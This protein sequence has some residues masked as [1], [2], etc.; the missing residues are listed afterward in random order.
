MMISAGRRRRRRSGAAKSRWL[1]LGSRVQYSWQRGQ[2]M[3]GA[4][5]SKIS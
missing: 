4:F 1:K 2:R 5:D 3:P